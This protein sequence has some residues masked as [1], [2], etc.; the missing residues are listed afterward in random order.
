MEEKNEGY[1]DKD[2]FFIMPQG[3]FIDP[4]GYYFDE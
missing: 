3:D 4:Y 2:G 1:Y